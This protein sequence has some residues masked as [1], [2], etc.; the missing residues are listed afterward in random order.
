MSK[1]GGQQQ[2]PTNQTVTQSSLPEE[3][4]PYLERTLQRAEGISNRPYEAYTGQRL[5]DFSDAT[6]ASFG[7]VTANQGAYQPYLDTAGSALDSGMAATTYA[8]NADARDVGTDQW[9]AAAAQQYMDPYLNTVLDN[10]R[11]RMYQDFNLQLNDIDQGAAMSGAFGGS[12]HGVMAA[13]ASRDFNQRL[14]EAEASAMSDAYRQGLG[15]FGTDRARMLEAERANQAAD[16]AGLDRALQGGA[17]MGEFANAAAGLGQMRSDLGY[18][19]AEALRRMGL[20]QEQLNQA[21]LDIGYTDFANQRDYERQNLAM[22]S[23]ILRGTPMPTSSEV[24]TTQYQNPYAQAL[25]LGLG[26]FGA[27]QNMGGG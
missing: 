3:F 11:N 20:T 5:A 1:G 27:S 26:L 8:V 22:L 7:Q 14:N 25:G 17:Q 24:T 9:N 2:Q 16:M 15:A 23:G 13:L 19:D 21:Q 18:A 10:Q 4:Y 12:R 6:R